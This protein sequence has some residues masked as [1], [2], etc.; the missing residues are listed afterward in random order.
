[1]TVSNTSYYN[2]TKVPFQ[3]GNINVTIG[4]DTTTF[5]G[6]P[7]PLWVQTMHTIIFFVIFFLPEITLALAIR[8]LIFTFRK[9]PKVKAKTRYFPKFRSKSKGSL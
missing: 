5:I 3:P 1:M 2:I 4:P 9:S 7:E 6:P 8:S